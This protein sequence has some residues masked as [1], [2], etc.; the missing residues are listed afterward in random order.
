MG[1]LNVQGQRRFEVIA[2]EATREAPAAPFVLLD[3]GLRVRS[4]S[5]AYEHVTL[6]KHGELI[7][8]FLFEAF[9][10]DPNDAQASGTSHLTAS[11]ETAMRSGHTHNMQILRYDIPE[12]TAPD[13]FLP[14]VWSPS[15]SPLIDHGEL[16][17]VIHR[18]GEVISESEHALAAIARAI[19]AGDTWTGADVV[20]TLAAVS[21]VQTAGYSE[22]QLA[23]V[24][25]NE[26]LRRAIDT[27]DTI[28]QAKGMLMER[29]NIDASAAFSLLVRLSQNT[30]T[31]LVQIAHKL[32]ELDHPP[33]S[34]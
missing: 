30:N 13:K 1:G 24:T 6:R 2:R 8:Q 7:G 20:H 26:Q 32:I 22:R 29:F 12:P 23:L 33:N 21:A 28:G 16:V 14:K 25:E 11:F 4:V 5:T 10:D 9:P 31:R 34:N 15:N 17:G 27:R 18:C 3:R 19:H